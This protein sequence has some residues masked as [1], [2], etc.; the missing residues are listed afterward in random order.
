MRNY[1]AKLCAKITHYKRHYKK[2][3]RYC[4]PNGHCGIDNSA[5]SLQRTDM[6]L[7][8]EPPQNPMEAHKQWMKLPAMTKSLTKLDV[9]IFHYYFKSLTAISN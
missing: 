2:Q 5:A 4:Q 8:T 1:N 6:Y 7:N 3:P 9:C